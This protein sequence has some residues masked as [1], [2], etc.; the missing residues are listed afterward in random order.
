MPILY[1]LKNEV[2]EANKNL[3]RLGLVTFTWGNV[4]GIDREEGIVVIK[5]SGVPYNELKVDH[6]VVI[7]LDG[8]IIEG[9]LK[10]SS[11][12]QTHLI[13]YKN[14]PNIGGVCHTHSLWATSYAQANIGIPVY[15]TTHADHFRGEI[16]C[17][18]P[19]TD[20]EIKGDYE[21]NTGRLIVDTFRK[22]N[23]DQIPGVLVASHGPFTWG[24]DANDAVQNS[25]VLEFIAEAAYR[26]SLLNSNISEI[27]VNLI[28]KHFLR[29]HGDSAYYGQ[30]SK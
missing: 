3:E 24:V 15:G 19:Y 25:R 7:D 11:D 12:T 30:D 17:S 21:A 20:E 10:P 18:R 28:D 9:D 14:F 5:P 6:M 23:E 2:L 22:I 27:N 16:P 26:T 8:N 4:S 13:L 1:T 29:K